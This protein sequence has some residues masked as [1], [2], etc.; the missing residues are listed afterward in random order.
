MS[1]LN[2]DWTQADIVKWDKS[3][4]NED[5]VR[6]GEL[7]EDEYVKY[8]EEVSGGKVAEDDA[9]AYYRNM[10]E[11]AGMEE[12]SDNPINFEHL[13]RPEQIAVTEEFEHQARKLSAAERSETAL[14]APGTFDHIDTDGD[15]EI[16][17]SEWG[18]Y[19][20][21][22][23]PGGD[24]LSPEMID[25]MFKVLANVPPGEPSTG[26]TI[27]KDEFND[28]SEGNSFSDV[29]MIQAA[30]MDVVESPK[31]EMELMIEALEELIAK[32]AEDDR[33]DDGFDS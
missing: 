26:H 27:T 3:V 16:N 19:V 33:L 17:E 7:T 30:T 29:Q 12:G 21:N 8:A 5:G 28:T 2:Q 13:S 18:N 11:A 15:G 14:D 6:D 1:D 9:R 22:D 23:M 32:M 20:R 4:A 24:L 31:S 10:Q 25:D